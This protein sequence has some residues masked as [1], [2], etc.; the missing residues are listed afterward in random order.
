M[1]RNNILF[2]APQD[3]LILNYA[4]WISWFSIFMIAPQNVVVLEGTAHYH[5]KL[6][7]M[8]DY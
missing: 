3:Q 1:Y 7:I 2:F 8:I 4:C 5:V 6:T